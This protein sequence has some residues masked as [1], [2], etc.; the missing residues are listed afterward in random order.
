MGGVFFQSLNGAAE[1]ISCA[2]NSNWCQPGVVVPGEVCAFARA[3]EGTLRTSVGG[4]LRELS[5]CFYNRTM[6]YKF[7]VGSNHP[8][9]YNH[10]LCPPQTDTVSILATPA[11]DTRSFPEFVTSLVTSLI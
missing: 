9:A 1:L 2:G 10:N 3:K 11:R 8:F 5:T 4:G 6:S 7:L